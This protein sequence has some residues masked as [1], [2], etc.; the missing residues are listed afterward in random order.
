MRTQAAAQLSTVI[1]TATLSAAVVA[2]DA[3]RE[4]GPALLVLAAVA[5]VPHGAADLALLDRSR[6]SVVLAY[7]LTAL[8]A[9]VVA[10]AVP[11]PAMVALLLLSVAHFTEGEVAFDRLRDPEASVWPGVALAT[12]IV[13]LPLARWPQDVRPLLL[14]L[15]P[16]LATVLGSTPGRAALG[17]VA[18]ALVM[19]G[20]WTADAPARVGLVLVVALAVTAPPLV[21]FAAWFAGWHAVRH[22]AR[23]QARRPLGPV[24]RAAVL[25][26]LAA[27]ALA[28]P[29]VQAVGGVSATVLLVLLA[30]TV[31]HSVVVATVLA[32]PR[33][34]ATDRRRVP[35]GERR[36][37]HPS[38]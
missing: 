18:A 36:T 15:S 37:R 33:S 38:G 26:S 31:P 16:W 27:V 29:L 14:D 34:P 19:T 35:S 10:L 3:V 23:V 2:P 12:S 13:A 20:L 22:L 7:G 30:L 8:A 25:P 32:H 9:V 1:V 6:R 28:V 24:L 17:I 4:A 5:G 21:A 11:G